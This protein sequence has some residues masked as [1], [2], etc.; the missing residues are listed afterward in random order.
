MHRLNDRDAN[1][2]EGR[3]IASRIPGATLLELPGKD[4]LIYAGDQDSVLLPVQNFLAGLQRPEETDT[5]L[6]TV[7]WVIPG[8]ESSPAHIR[9]FRAIAARETEWFKGRETGSEQ[10]G[11]VAIFDGPVRAVRCACAIGKATQ[12]AGLQTRIAVHT[13]LCEVT[14]DKIVGPAPEISRKLAYAIESGEMIVSNST[15]DLMS[16]SGITFRKD[17]LRSLAGVA[18]I[19]LVD[20]ENYFPQ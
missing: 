10:N 16:G 15:Q 13:G 7:L 3:F 1:I 19:F 6:A 14:G 12:Q 8:G 2:A 17:E 18:E 9:R 4:H 20:C 11:F 5:V